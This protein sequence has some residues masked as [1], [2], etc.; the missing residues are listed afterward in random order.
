M[1]SI[2]AGRDL[3]SKG[4]WLGVSKSGKIAAVTNFRDPASQKEN[5]PSRG[6]LVSN[7]LSG[8]ESP[9]S[10]LEHIKT[11]GHLYNGFNLIIGDG[12]ELYH[13]SNK[14]NDIQRVEPGLY[15]LS[16]HLLDTPWPKVEKGKTDFQAMLAVKKEINLEDIFKILSDRSYP[17]DDK[18]P[19]TGVGLE[20]ERLL[21]SIFITSEDYGTH[22]SS[23]VLM[24]KTGK[25]TFVERTFISEGIRTVDH[26]TRE[27]SIDK[28]AGF[29][30]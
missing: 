28:P 5:A 6:L 27:F 4:T 25:I 15:G 22:S 21:S 11:I 3:K 23:I 24:E 30:K 12:S 9:K 1:P 20:R 14:G 7:Y 19:D 29:D 2:L 8:K 16:N 17:P 26:K 13:Y 18:L 10:Y